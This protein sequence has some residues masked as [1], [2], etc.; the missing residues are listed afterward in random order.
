MTSPTAAR[1]RDSIVAGAVAGLAAGLV[2]AALHAVIIVPVWDRMV[3]SLMLAVL[4]GSVIGWSYAELYPEQSD[5]AASAWSGSRYGA[6]LWLAV[7]PVSLADAALRAVGFLPRY[8][9]VGLVVAVAI[10][11]AAGAL[12]GWRRTGRRRGL[13]ASA[14][15][16]LALTMVMGG[17]VP[18]ARNVWA[19][20]IFLAVLPASIVAG[21]ILGASVAL[22]RRRTTAMAP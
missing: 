3:G 14:A 10:A 4:A 21:A 7:V 22:A 11:V 13:A 18:F 2:F 12:W 8:E 6:L 1:V 20:G 17:P 15:A 5:V 16:T 9:L 19:F